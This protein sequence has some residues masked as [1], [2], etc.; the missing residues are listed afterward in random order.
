MKFL[1]QGGVSVKA[2]SVGFTHGLTFRHSQSR[3]KMSPELL[4]IV[5]IVGCA[6]LK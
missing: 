3:T 2:H 6:D 1:K 4:D 5:E